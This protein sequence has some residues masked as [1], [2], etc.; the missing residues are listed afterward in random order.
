MPADLQ[1]VGTRWVL[2]EKANGTA[3]ARLVVQGCQEKTNDIRSDSPTGSRDCLML[4]LIHAAQRG[5]SVSQFDADCAYLQSKGI[6]RTL[7]LRIPRRHPP[8]G[9][10]P[11]ALAIATSAIYGTKDAGRHWYMH[12]RKHLQQAGFFESRLEKGTYGFHVDGKLVCMIHTHVDDPLFARQ[13]DCPVLDTIIA[14]LTEDLHLRMSEGDVLTYLG[15]R[16]EFKKDET[17]VTQVEA[18]ETLEPIVLNSPAARRCLPS[19]FPAHGET[20]ERLQKPRRLYP[21]AH[22][23]DA[24]RLRGPRI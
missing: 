12:P 6:N 9:Q 3:K 17:R 2:T 10:E 19:R 22:P 23:T 16:V 24:P 7:V 13:M 5:W 20:A 4:A 14:K 1:I 11:S 8:P 15:R 21:V 18:A